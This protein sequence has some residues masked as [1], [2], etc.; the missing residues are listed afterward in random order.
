MN[1]NCLTE[2]EKEILLQV[3]RSAITAAVSALALPNIDVNKQPDLL[4]ENGASFVTLTLEGRL[5]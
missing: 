4:R 1:K 5:R 3:A 2:K